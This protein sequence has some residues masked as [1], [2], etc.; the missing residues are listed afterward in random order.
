MLTPNGYWYAVY[1]YPNLERK[2]YS[3]LIK[4]TVL[5]YLPLRKVVRQWS[6]R[7]KEL[8]IPLFPNYLFVRIHDHERANV[9]KVSG[10]ARF[11]AFDNQLAIIPNEEIETIRKL[12]RVSVEL[13]SRLITGD[14]VQIMR[15]PLQGLKGVLF[16]K[17]GKERFGMQLEGLQ[18]ALSLDV[19]VNLLKK[20]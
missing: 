11:V 2:I 1:T 6:D 4:Q 5:A 10:V 19:C 17:K 16:K 14:R 3:A 20:L 7:V 15:G 18:Q 13:E 8:E 9:L 12:E